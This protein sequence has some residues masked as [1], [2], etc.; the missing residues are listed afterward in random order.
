MGGWHRGTCFESCIHLLDMI[1]ADFGGDP[2]RVYALGASMGGGGAWALAGK[3]P[4]RF[5]AV[6][7]CAGHLDTDAGKTGQKDLVLANLLDKPVWVFH[8]ADD[9]VAPVE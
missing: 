5:A 7:P 3:H 4:E 1:T 8:S 2:S 6:V 9:N